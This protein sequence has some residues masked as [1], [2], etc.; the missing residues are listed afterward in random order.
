MAGSAACKK[1]SAAPTTSSEE[2]M[3]DS[4]TKQDHLYEETIAGYGAALERLSRAYEFEPEKRSDLLQEIHLA[5]WRSFASFEGQCS[6]RTWIYRV[7]HNVAATH[8]DRGRRQRARVFVTLEEAA[9]MAAEGD[10]LV[11][12][13]RRKNLDR[14]YTLIHALEPIDRQI[15]LLYLEGFVG[16]E[17]GEITGISATNVATRVHRVKKLLTQRF[18][19]GGPR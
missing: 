5:L 11:L 4:A 3:D 9:A 6:L 10:P 1:V 12:A 16:A 15:I 13:D 8:V 7:A 19:Q 14:L 17:I 2:A 18:N